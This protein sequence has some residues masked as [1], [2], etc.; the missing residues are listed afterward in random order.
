MFALCGASSV[1]YPILIS[2]ELSTPASPYR[3]TDFVER[4]IISLREVKFLVLDEA[5]RMLDM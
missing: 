1:V 3:L 5:D 4:N 2:H